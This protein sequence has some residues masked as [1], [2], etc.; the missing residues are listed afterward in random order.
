MK[1]ELTI[2]GTSAAVP[3]HNRGLSG[4]V[5]NIRERLF[6]ID[7]GEG[8][9]MSL[10]KYS[11]KKSKINHIFISHLH[12]DHVFGLAGVLTSMAM[13]SRKHVLTIFGPK[14]VEEYVMTI[15][16][17]THYVSPFP[18]QFVEIDHTVVTQLIDNEV[19][20]VKSFP[21]KHRVPTVGYVFKERPFERNIKAEKIK[22]YNIPFTAI[23]AI[24][25]G[26]DFRDTEGVVVPN[27]ELTIPPPKPRS[28]AYCSDTA[29]DPTIATHIYGVDLLYHETTF[30]HEMAILAEERGHATA[31]QAGQI[32][33]SA[34]VGQLVTGHYSSR[35]DELAFFLEE[36]KRAFEN[37][38]LGT[39][40]QTYSVPIVKNI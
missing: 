32:A 23:K 29:F 26:A 4:Q 3:Y 14:G 21:L 30:L 7:C 6:L 27:E 20:E 18:I 2:L 36:A 1:F 33:A 37:V 40:G 35:Y 13:E 12:G 22:E 31:F 38:V 25:Q 8:T 9:Q 39:D 34:E 19:F 28:F 5:L 17:L 10:N 15:F 24:K 11:V 16:R